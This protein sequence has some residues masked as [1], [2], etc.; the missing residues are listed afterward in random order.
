M[1][2]ILSFFAYLYS[3]NKEA[4]KKAVAISPMRGYSCSAADAAVLSY[5]PVLLKTR[6]FSAPASWDVRR[7]APL[8]DFD[9]ASSKLRAHKFRAHLAWLRLNVLGA[10]CDSQVRAL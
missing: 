10:S 4:K 7:C 8:L 6:S 3:Q 1:P 2:Q 9:L 5:C